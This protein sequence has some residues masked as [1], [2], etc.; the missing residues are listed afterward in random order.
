MHDDILP[1]ELLAT[2]NSQFPCREAQLRRLAALIGNDDSASP[3]AIVVHGLEATGKSLILRS[4]LTGVQAAFTWVSCDECITARQLCERI[5][6]G[7]AANVGSTASASD[8]G[9]GRAENATSLAVNLTAALKD[10]GRKHFLVLDRADRQREAAAGS[11]LLAALARLGE[12]VPLLTVLFVVTVPKTG[13]LS[14][15]EVPHVYFSPYSKEESIKVLSKYARR[16]TIPRD[17]EEG[18]EREE[19]EE[20]DGGDD[21]DDAKEELY[22]WQKFCGTVW[23]ALAKGT[24]RNVVQFRAIVDE[25]W[26]PFVKPIADGKYGTRNYSSL[27]L[28]HKDMFQRETNIVDSVLPHRNGEK[29][30]VKSEYLLFVRAFFFFLLSLAFDTDAENSSTRSPLLLKIPAVCSIPCVVQPSTTG[31]PLLHES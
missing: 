13:F 12:I 17:E 30:V 31:R 4:Y 19:E 2:L 26:E 3:P 21:D 15:A 28:L 9:V 16:I 29:V 10:V 7:V 24:A 14:C 22:V 27:Y 23:D 11:L 6:T 8:G 1:T 20:E 5:A 18:Q 25:M